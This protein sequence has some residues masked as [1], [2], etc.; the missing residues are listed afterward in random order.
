MFKTMNSY[1]ALEHNR[2]VKIVPLTLKDLGIRGISSL[3]QRGVT[4]TVSNVGK[5]T[6][7]EIMVPYI[8]KFSSFM[9]H[10]QCTDV[11]QLF[12]G[13]AYLRCDDGIY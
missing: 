2:A 1:A 12:S 3:M 10:Q 6:M 13:C 7:P 4:S 5:V 11:H 9:S 8:E